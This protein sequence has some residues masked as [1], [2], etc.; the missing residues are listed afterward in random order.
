MRCIFDTDQCIL[1]GRTRT[2]TA[3][4]T[5]TPRDTFCANTG[6]AVNL[7]TGRSCSFVPVTI[8]I[9]KKPTLY[10]DYIVVL[11]TP[12]YY[13]EYSL[14]L[15]CWNAYAYR[16]QIGSFTLPFSTEFG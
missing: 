6:F 4:A 7:T 11:I 13:L 10:G 1:G 12:P 9:A 15:F 8:R 5:V 3:F 16:L 2:T 14:L